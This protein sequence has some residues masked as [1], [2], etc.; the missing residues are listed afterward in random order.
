MF[1]PFNVL[2]FYWFNVFK[3]KQMGALDEYTLLLG[4]PSEWYPRPA[5]VAVELLDWW[6][7]SHI[8]LWWNSNETFVGLTQEWLGAGINYVTLLFVKIHTLT[9]VSSSS[10]QWTRLIVLVDCAIWL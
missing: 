9:I 5:Y 8:F 7:L 3:I 10:T 2:L 1:N 4:Q 6:T